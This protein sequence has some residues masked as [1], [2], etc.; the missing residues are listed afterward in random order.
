MK[1]ITPILFAA[2]LAT[3]SIEARTEI[4]LIELYKELHS[5]PEL[6]YKEVN[7]SKKLAKIIQ[8]MGFKVTQNFGGYGVVAL[9]ENGI[10]KL[11]T[12]FSILAS[13][14]FTKSG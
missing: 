1:I 13:V 3:T 5:N 12:K 4:N 7:T 10:G 9:L 11:H 6:S 14:I 2:L 8:T